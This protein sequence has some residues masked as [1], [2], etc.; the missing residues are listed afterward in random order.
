MKKLD[1]EES[2]R[3][4]SINYYEILEEEDNDLSSEDYN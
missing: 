2:S 4:S 3:I 1:L